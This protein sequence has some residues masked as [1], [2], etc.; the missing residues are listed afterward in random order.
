MFRL[1]Y[2]RLPD[3][4]ID[5]SRHDGIKSTPVYRLKRIAEILEEHDQ[6]L[7]SDDGPVRQEPL[8]LR[9]IYLLAIGPQKERKQL[10]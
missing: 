5:M 2:V 10:T 9:E 4:E 7:L 3:K 6:W 8:Y 1:V